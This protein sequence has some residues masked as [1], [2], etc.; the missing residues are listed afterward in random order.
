[1]KYSQPAG[2]VAAIAVIAICYMPWVFIQSINV[3][4]TGMQSDGTAFGK[5]GLLNIAF[6]ILSI[7][8]FSIQKIWAKRTNPFITTINMAWALRN[9]LLISTCQGG[10]C[11]DKKA[12]I[13]LLLIASGVML[14]MSLLPKLKVPGE[15]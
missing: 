15:K 13:F 10:E 2:I 6:S 1:M 4:V 11:P 12:G 7:I 8:F 14:V 5:P 3:T 9:Y